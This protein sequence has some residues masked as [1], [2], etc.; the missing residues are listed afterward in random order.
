MKYF[1]ITLFVLVFS[2][3][4]TTPGSIRANSTAELPNIQEI[5]QDRFSQTVRGMAL[6]NFQQLWPEALKSGE[7]V[8]FVIYE[9]RHSILYHTDADYSTAFWWT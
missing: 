9:F 1:L 2:S 5:Y 4:I 3:C 6:S 7:T 8:D